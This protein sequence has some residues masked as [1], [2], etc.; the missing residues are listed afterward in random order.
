M[1]PPPDDAPLRDQGAQRAGAAHPARTGPSAARRE[2]DA[3]SEA[4][5]ARREDDAESEAAA[6]RR[7]WTLRAALLLTFALAARTFFA[8]P[9][10]APPI[11][12]MPELG[13]GAGRLLYGLPLDLNRAPEQALYALPRIGPSLAAAIVAGRPYCE[14]EGLLRVNGIGPKT[15]AG[16]QGRVEVAE[17]PGTCPSPRGNAGS[18]NR[19]G[20]PPG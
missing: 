19:H 4:G 7:R 9:Q 14:V 20:Q 2:G 12:P 11:A 15:L 13:D 10:T 5:A 16:L 3:E 18:S 6:R 17:P 8:A 1:T